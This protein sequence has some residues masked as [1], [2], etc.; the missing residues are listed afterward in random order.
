MPITNIPKSI[1]L[2]TSPEKND[3]ATVTYV[4]EDKMF[5]ITGT[6]GGFVHIW[7]FLQPYPSSEEKRLISSYFKERERRMKTLGWSNINGKPDVSFKAHE[8]SIISLQITPKMFSRGKIDYILVTTSL[9]RT[10]KL[11]K[12]SKVDKSQNKLKLKINECEYSSAGNGKDKG[13]RIEL[14]GWF[15]DLEDIF[16]HA[17]FIPNTGNK[18]IVTRYMG[19]VEKFKL[20]LL[21]STSN[22]TSERN[23]TSIAR[24]YTD[25]SRMVGSISTSCNYYAV[26]GVSGNVSVYDVET[27]QLLDSCE[28][29]NAEGPNSTGKDVTGIDWNKKD[30]FMLVTT[31]DSR[32]RL[33]SFKNKYLTNVYPEEYGNHMKYGVDNSSARDKRLRYVE[34]FKGHTNR[35]IYYKAKFF[36]T[37]EEIVMCPSESG[38]IYVWK[39]ESPLY[40]NN[41][42]KGVKV[43]DEEEKLNL[44]N[45]VVKN[46][47]FYGFKIGEKSLLASLDIYNVNEWDKLLK[48]IL[49][50]RRK[51]AEEGE[52]KTCLICR[53]TPKNENPCPNN[54]VLMVSSQNGSE[55]KYS[56]IDVRYF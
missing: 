36:G 35:K 8:S 38:H 25:Q 44:D 21:D 2:V 37:N 45:G 15:E 26:G 41:Q 20:D 31:L 1:E 48:V 14:I 23:M 51:E 49:S 42:V 13:A 9:D 10:L 46:K 56:V 28:C 27:L 40:N 30:D 29:R 7:S 34:K 12:I 5:L 4:S 3:K 55:I 11:W 16:V 19:W 53:K 17:S 22:K 18:I 6:L 43:K 47:D 52:R 39:I 32:I 54:D 24:V 50:S 33:L